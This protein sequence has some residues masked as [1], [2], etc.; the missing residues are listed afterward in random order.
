MS[1][2]YIAENGRLTKAEHAELSEK[3]FKLKNANDHWGVIDLL[4]KAWSEDAPEEVEAL[5]IQIDDYKEKL[6]DKKFG[7][8]KHGKDIERRFTLSFPRGLMLL[9]RTVYKPEELTFDKEFFGDF[10]KRYPY[11]RVAES[12]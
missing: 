10:I 3:V 8:T 7:Q 5:R 9:I 4:L 2:V 6:I 1:D 12:G 11:F